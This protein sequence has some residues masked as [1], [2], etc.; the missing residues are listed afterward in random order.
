MRSKRTIL[1]ILAG[2]WTT[3]LIIE[4]TFNAVSSVKARNS[5]FPLKILFL[6]ARIFRSALILCLVVVN[7]FMAIALIDDKK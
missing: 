2:I 6:M 4:K 1:Y 5:A 7:V 3:L